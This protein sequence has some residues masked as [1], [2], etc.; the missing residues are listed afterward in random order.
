MELYTKSQPSNF[1]LFLSQQPTVEKHV[2]SVM[3]DEPVNDVWSS[4]L[5]TLVLT[6]QE[7]IAQKVQNEVHIRNVNNNKRVSGDCLSRGFTMHKKN[8]VIVLIL[9]WFSLIQWQTESIKPIQIATQ[10]LFHTNKQ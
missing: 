7:R 8:V 2:K 4:V 9:I 10:P 6:H 3:K 1:Y 5:P